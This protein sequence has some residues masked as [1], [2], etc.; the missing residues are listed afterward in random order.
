MNRAALRALL[1][2]TEFHDFHRDPNINYQL[3]RFLIPGLERLLAHLGKTIVDFTDWKREFFEAASVREK[4]GELASAAALYRAAE[5]FI[6][7]ADPDRWRAYEKF[8]DLF[9]RAN[10]NTGL[11]PIE[12][13]YERGPLHGLRVPAPSP[14][15]GMVL[16][17]AGYDA[18]VE[19]FLGLAEAVSACGHDVIMFDGPGQGSTLMRNKIPMTPA[20]EKPVAAV[21]DHLALSNVTLIG[22]S[23]GGCLA[24]RAAAREPRVQRVIAFDVMLDFFDCITSRRGKAG[25]FLL[26]ALLRLKLTPLLN[27]VAYLTMKRDLYSRWGIEQGMHVIGCELRQRSLRRFATTRPVRSHPSSPRMF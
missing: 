25:R 2:I 23:L 7:P 3:N 9:W 24:L 19:E 26:S 10:A 16:M 14:S 12:I 5:F 22:I 6:S 11:E 21:L 18:Y 8:M 20:W 15:R 27:A 4:S 13:P 1:P 17:H